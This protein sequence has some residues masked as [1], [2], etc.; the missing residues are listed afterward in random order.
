MLYDDS[1]LFQSLLLDALLIQLFQ[2]GEEVMQVKCHLG[3]DEPEVYHK[4][5][6]ENKAFY[7]WLR[8]IVR[9]LA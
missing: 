9:W 5:S 2:Q 8:N 7:K 6:R 3:R 1:S 4:T